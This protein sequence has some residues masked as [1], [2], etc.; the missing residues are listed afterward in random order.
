[1]RQKLRSKLVRQLKMK[2]SG[3]T[4]G[5]IRVLCYDSSAWV[6][7]NFTRRAAEYNETAPEGFKMSFDYTSDTLSTTSATNSA[8]YDVICLFVNDDAGA[9][10]LKTVS[11]CG[12]KMIA[13][14]CAGFDRV[15]K[16]MAETLGLTV[17]RVPAYR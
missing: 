11:M 15:D 17:A 3:G 2:T 12:V 16:S 9:E 7:D 5:G 4:G 14:R 10:T 13:M 1:E 6:R 8:G